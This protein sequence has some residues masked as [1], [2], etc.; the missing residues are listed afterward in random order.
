MFN[1]HKVSEPQS[2]AIYHYYSAREIVLRK[3]YFLL[4]I[5]PL[6]AATLLV[7]LHSEAKLIV[8]HVGCG[9]IYGIVAER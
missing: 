1:V 7:L 8:P 6:G 9:Q 3:L 4:D 2:Y 5:G